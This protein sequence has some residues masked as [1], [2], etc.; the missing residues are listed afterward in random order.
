MRLCWAT[1]VL[2]GE[3]ARTVLKAAASNKGGKGGE[4]RLRYVQLGNSAG[5][6]VTLRADTLPDS[7]LQL[8]ES[9]IGSVATKELLDGAAEL[10]SRPSE[11]GSKPALTSVP[12]T[13]V[14]R[15]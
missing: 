10:L 4:P 11:A 5:A 8:L 3:P 13:D 1:S 6:K 9:G 15:F 12:L 2:W 7:V 14:A